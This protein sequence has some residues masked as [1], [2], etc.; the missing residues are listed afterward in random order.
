MNDP[1]KTQLDQLRNTLGK[2]EV[3][4]SAL[5][6]AIVWTDQTGRIQW[7]NQA[8]VSLVKE[9]RITLIGKELADVLTLQQQGRP[10][11]RTK[12]PALL[13]H[14][15][16]DDITSVYEYIKDEQRYD[17]EISATCIWEKDAS[18][19]SII[20]IV[21]DISELQIAKQ[22]RVQGKALSAAVS[23]IIITDDKGV[24]EWVNPAFQ[25]MS[26][27]SLEECVGQQFWFQN[28]ARDHIKFKREL[29]QTLERGETWQKE[30]SNRRKDG[31]FYHEQESISPVF[32]N[33]GELQ[34]FIAIKEDISE[35]KKFEAAILERE[36]RIRAILNSA[37]DSI[38]IIDVQGEIQSFNDAALAMF[39][40]DQAELTGQNVRILM[41]EPHRSAHDGYLH[42]YLQSKRKHVIG[43][44]RE[45]QAVRKDGSL[46][47]IELSL[48]EAKI[49]ESFLFSGFIRDITKRV[50]SQEELAQAHAD[51]LVKQKLINADLSAAAGIQVSLLPQAQPE[52][53]CLEAAWKFQPSTFVGGDIFNFFQ[54]DADNF[55]AYIV[56][57]SGHGVPSALISVSIYQTLSQHSSSL[58]DKDG[59][60]VLSPSRVLNVLEQEFPIERFNNFF[61][62]FFMTI[63][64]RT[65]M[66][67]YSAGGHPPALLLRKGA[68]PKLLDAGGMI[69]GAGAP[70][71]F[72]EACMFLQ[73]GDKIIMY[74][75]GTYEYENEN[76]QM[77]GLD[78]LY[79][80][81][82]AQREKTIA[83][84]IDGIFEDIMN[85]GGHLM[86]QD[87]IS[88]L[89]FEYG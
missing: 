65:G 41:P 7:C 25:V 52:T 70:I 23:S 9:I 67:T 12:H 59:R 30:I 57:V 8:F 61:T 66:L 55:I 17:I 86:P 33:Q 83:A 64:P 79:A 32:S 36:A 34:H 85:C 3:A 47:P 20:M 4:F 78:R 29:R 89:G 38:I 5:R 74:T 80:T 21:R 39:G 37:T 54:L 53:A 76:Q 44:T 18:A 27:Y 11:S 43:I 71:P 22:I 84:A 40:Y 24:I 50:E 63:N 16:G 48:S 87:D 56:D 13:I 62:I 72:A 82:A 88:L 73:K 49:G 26:G 58:F 60:T 81:I 6:D 46:F 45:L 68:E 31:T 75:D 2:M 1:L 28:P 19:C 15:P 42:K 14:K 35:R 51:L 10:V 77:Y 69:I